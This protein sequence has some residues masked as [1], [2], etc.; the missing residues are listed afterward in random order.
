MAWGSAPVVGMGVA[1]VLLTIGFVLWEGHAPEPILPLR[2]FDNGIFRVI[3]GLML[4]MGGIMFGATQFLPL[5][6]QAVDGVSAT[7]SGLLMV[8][9]MAGVTISSIGSGRL[10]AIT[11]RYKRWPVIGM[12]LATVGTAMLATLSPDVSRV[13][14]STGM[15]LLGLGLGMTMPTSTLAVQNSVEFRDMGVATSMVT[16]FRSLGGCIGLAIYG[17]I[18]NAKIMASGVDETLLQAPDS[19]KLLPL[20]GPDRGH[21]RAVR[22]R[23]RH[24]RGRRAD[25]VPG[26]DPDAVPEG[27]PAARDDGALRRPVVRAGRSGW[28]CGGRCPAEPRTAR[29]EPRPTPPSTSPPPAPSS[30]EPRGA[31]IRYRIGDVSRSAIGSQRSRLTR[32]VTPKPRQRIGTESAPYRAEGGWRSGMA[33]WVGVAMGASHATTPRQASDEAS[34]TSK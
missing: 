21:R 6:L 10:T 15:L 27:D 24:V 30:T 29:P 16:F 31:P 19:I 17:A 23:G 22:C 20:D 2:L 9:L 1:T 8:P 11:G 4:L 34:I 14:I 12:G 26:L 32:C 18:F 7:Q 28:R 3:A 25:R 33:Q 13:V 5:F